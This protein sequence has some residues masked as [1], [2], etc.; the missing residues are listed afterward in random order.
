MRWKILFL[1]AVLLAALPVARAADVPFVRGDT[2]NDGAVDVVDSANILAYLFSGAPDL[3]CEDATDNNDDG[4]VNIADAI[5]V[6]GQS[7]GGQT[8]PHPPQGAPGPDPNEDARGCESYPPH[9]PILEVATMLTGDPVTILGVE[10]NAAITTLRITT[11]LPIHALQF[12]ARVEGVDGA[13]ILTQDYYQDPALAFRMECADNETIQLITSFRATWFVGPGDD[14]PVVN[15]DVC[16]PLGTQ[17]GTYDL[18]SENSRAS[19]LEDINAHVTEAARIPIT[20][21]STI[22]VEGCEIPDPPDPPDPSHRDIRLEL[23]GPT[24]LEP[25]AHGFTVS[26]FLRSPY[27]ILG[28]VAAIDYSEYVLSLEN[29]RATFDVGGLTPDTFD[30]LVGPDTVQTV[31]NDPF[32]GYVRLTAE[33]PSGVTETWDPER[34]YKVAELDFALKPEA[35]ESIQTTLYLR[36]VGPGQQYANEVRYV[37]DD[38][39]VTSQ[40][41]RLNN[42]VIVIGGDSIPV[43][44][45]IE[46]LEVT[47][48]LSEAA[49]NPGDEQIP[50][51]FYMNSNSGLEGFSAGFTYDR[52]M[53][54]IESFTSLAHINGEEPD[55]VSVKTFTPEAPGGRHGAIIGVVASFMQEF[56]YYPD[57]D[58]PI[59]VARFTILNEAEPGS[60]GIL[61]FVNT[62]GTPPVENAVVFHGVA[63]PPGIQDSVMILRHG[64]VKVMGEVSPFLVRGDANTDFRV[65]LSDAI[66]ILAYLF[67]NG[68]P[69]T[70]P[71]AADATDDGK[72][73]I[74]DPIAILNTLFT[75]NML[76]APPYPEVGS[77]PTVDQLARCSY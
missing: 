1:T 34:R 53:L 75:A 49:G 6:L 74:V 72:I 52:D 41:G 63:V 40:P 10:R 60:E 17:A 13:R 25:D 24:S 65:D 26:V 16:L 66:T 73:G 76:I 36:K 58:E 5:S 2:N 21:E 8:N 69:S 45:T 61:S 54:L 56:Y 19:V 39:E 70:C 57:P 12:T 48:R 4:A 46:D 23:G 64:K 77:D 37:T 20:V 68:P 22:T 28:L 15:L 35:G 51:Y 71:D 44:P 31:A 29:V 33:M 38:G 43:V 59:A 27:P 11:D 50:V 55:F 32:E 42:L 18:V 67:K 9:E 7:C 14:V 47:Y 62:I 3:P 30:V